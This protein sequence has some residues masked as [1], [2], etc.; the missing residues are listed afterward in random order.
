MKILITDPVDK[1]LINVL[2]GAGFKVIYEPE[3]THD[4]LKQRIK[5]ID[6]I[7]VRSRTK[8]RKDIIDAA[9]KLR[10]IAR[11]GVGL[12]NIDVEYAEKRGISVV[13]AGGAT[14]Q[15][16]AELTIGLL[17]GLIRK[18]Y[19]GYSQLQKGRWVKKEIM[20]YELAGKTLGIIGVGNIG[21]RVGW[22]A[23]H[24]F[25]MRVLGYRRNIVKIDPPI[26]PVGLDK[27]LR[28]SDVISIHIPLNKET[29]GYI[30]EGKIKKMKE[31]VLIINTSRMEVLD[32]DAVIQALKSGKIGGLAADTNLKP[33]HPKISEL[34]SLPNVFLTPH[35]G[36]QTVEAQ[37]RAALYV[38]NLVI[39]LLLRSKR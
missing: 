4:E 11:V 22:I 34:L 36:A 15:S 10:V 27:L 19:Y 21:Y 32:L 31:G 38:A 9:L 35:I 8:V 37:R 7:I 1:S 20:G 24:G 6:A 13:N 2:M 39:D 28:E 25:S 16:V 3:I 29:Y 33:E 5:D 23:Y 26:I 30:D 18:I 12:D 14:A 17:I